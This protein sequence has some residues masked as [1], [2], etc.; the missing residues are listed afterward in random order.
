MS[1]SSSFYDNERGSRSPDAYDNDDEIVW[2]AASPTES[3][4]SD[5]SSQNDTSPVA[6]TSATSRSAS[7]TTMHSAPGSPPSKYSGSLAQPKT[8]HPYRSSI[9]PA[10][11]M[12]PRGLTPLSSSTTPLPLGTGQLPKAQPLSRTLFARMAS[13]T[14]HAGLGG[15][16]KKSGGQKLIVPTKGFK[17]T[18]EIGLTANELA[19]K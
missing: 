1:I 6:S 2:E 14:P 3:D 8:T 11:P 9:T 5:S 15:G 16:K 13:D 7:F 17:T 12:R 4:S 18:F 19:R 10:R